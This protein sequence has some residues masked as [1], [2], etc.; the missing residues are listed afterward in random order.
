[1]STQGQ[2]P[3]ISFE[4]VWK[5]F[6]RGEIHDSLRDLI[7][8]VG[9][10]L[11]GRGEKNRR[12]R[13]NDFWALRDVS[14]QVEPG[15][16]LGIIGGNGAGKSTTLKILTRIL[17]PTSGVAAVRGRIGALIE[18]SAG[19][20]QDLTGRE[21]VFLQG[22]IMGMPVALI[23]QKFDEI[24]EFAGIAEFIDTPVKRYSSGMNARL[25]F[26]I[27]AH[28]DPEVLIIDEVLSVGDYRFQEK[29]FGRIHDMARSGI[30]VVLVSHQL[31]R[32]ATL[33]TKAL[34][35][36]QGAVMQQGEVSRCIDA[37]LSG[38]LNLE[39]SGASVAPLRLSACR[40]LGGHNLV[41]GQDIVV[42]VDGV[43]TGIDRGAFDCIGIRIRALEG[44][45]E[46]FMTTTRL[47]GLV[48]PERGTVR[49]RLALRMSLAR[50]TYT[51]EPFA[52]RPGDDHIVCTGPISTFHMEVPANPIAAGTVDLLPRLELHQIDGGAMAPAAR[53]SAG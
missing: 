23:R 38:G 40:I 52:W 47:A 20:H 25:G 26:S 37:Y 28:L 32:V 27:A 41:W 21:N 30:P 22:S 34:L 6:R 8:A 17:R 16:V 5:R 44:G 18:V 39:G 33:C 29:A 9:R 31:D 13:E 14:F 15:E 1:M 51:I 24:V 53:S 45:R 36:Q 11:F 50:G 43:I 10:R 12:E 7:P 48:L 19:F 42:E 4:R 3:G 49:C 35:L 2:T 46:V